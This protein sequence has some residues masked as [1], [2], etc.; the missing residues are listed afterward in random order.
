MLKTVL[1]ALSLLCVSFT[2]AGVAS[3][4]TVPVGVCVAGQNEPSC[5]G[6]HDVCVSVS[7]M[8]PACFDSPARVI[9]CGDL[10]PPPNPTV[11]VPVCVG[12]AMCAPCNDGWAWIGV[13]TDPLHGHWVCGECEACGNPL[14]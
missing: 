2:F 4:M 8:V 3:A 14:L 9:T 12:Y 13:E 1:A 7:E 10:C 5:Y 11:T 6:G